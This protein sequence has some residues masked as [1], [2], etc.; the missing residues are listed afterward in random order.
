MPVFISC[1]CP[2]KDYQHLINE[3]EFGDRMNL[4]MLHNLKISETISHLVQ[5]HWVS[6]FH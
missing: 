2:H 4:G 6:Y 5:G 1:F 3:E